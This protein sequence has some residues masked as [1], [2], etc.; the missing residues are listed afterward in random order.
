[1]LNDQA[2]SSCSRRHQPLIAIAQ[3]TFYVRHANEQ[4]R[5]ER[6][7]RM[8]SMDLISLN[9]LEACTYS[10]GHRLFFKIIDRSTF[11]SF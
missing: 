9:L 7:G 5:T 2:P 8:L 3:L 11:Y 1:M 4:T 10:S 6:V